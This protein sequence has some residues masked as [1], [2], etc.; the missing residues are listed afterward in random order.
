MMIMKS[1][2]DYIYD[3]VKEGVISKKVA[4]E[5]FKRDNRFK[6]TDKYSVGQLKSMIL[7]ELKSRKS[8][9]VHPSVLVKK[10]KVDGRKLNIAMEMLAREGKI[11]FD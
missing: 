4:N 6:N 7:K 5:Y 2:K 3:K 1:F 9:R 8:K 10:W 11:R